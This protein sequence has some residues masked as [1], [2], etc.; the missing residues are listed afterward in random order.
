MNWI[1][2][3]ISSSL[4][5]EMKDYITLLWLNKRRKISMAQLVNDAVCY[6]LIRTGHE[7]K[8]VKAGKLPFKDDTIVSSGAL[9]VEYLKA[10]RTG[11]L[12]RIRSGQP[13]NAAFLRE[14]DAG[15]KKVVYDN[16]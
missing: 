14:L 8:Y 6:Y 5:N 12:S 3:R 9:E 2:I 10:W 7:L 15:L 11:L 1:N 4:R 16:K 13:V